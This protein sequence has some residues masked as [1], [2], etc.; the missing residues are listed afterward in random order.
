MSEATA[1]FL[2]PGRRAIPVAEHVRH[3]G[4]Q[5]SKGQGVTDPQCRRWRTVFRPGAMV[6]RPEDDR[7]EV[8]HI[9]DGQSRPTGQ[10]HLDHRSTGLVEAAE[11]RRHRG[12]IVRYDQVPSGQIVREL[13]R[14]GLS[15][16]RYMTGSSNERAMADDT[17]DSHNLCIAVSCPRA[18]RAWH[19]RDRHLSDE[20]A[21]VYHHLRLSPQ[22][23]SSCGW[24]R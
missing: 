7:A 1:W 5:G 13:L 9:V 2:F 21:R 3:R 20:E 8:V 12:G 18:P 11:T 17:G 16:T 4:P 6:T 15:L 10:P 19:L 24:A 22:V 14:C 23:F